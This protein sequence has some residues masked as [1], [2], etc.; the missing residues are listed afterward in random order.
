MHET[1]KKLM[2]VSVLLFVLISG[3]TG[4]YSASIPKSS[5][6]GSIHTETVTLYRYGPDGTITP[7]NIN[8]A[9]QEGQNPDEAIAQKCSE[10]VSTDIG[11]QTYLSGNNNMTNVSMFA[12]VTS[13][14]AGSHLKSFF[15]IRIPFLSLLKYGLLQ[16]LPLRY[17]I[18]GPRWIPIIV[19]N[20]SKDEGAKTSIETVPTPIRPNKTEITIEGKHAIWVSYFVGYVGWRGTS[21]DFYDTRG[22]R[23]GFDGYASFIIYE[24][25]S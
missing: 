25:F 16:N 12:R 5:T 13:F 19:C 20:Y 3:L 17:K 7:I 11:I 24:K 22:L 8:I 18:F 1:T 21:A 9:F 2:V 15:S 23:T 10:L 4:A 6:D 14:G